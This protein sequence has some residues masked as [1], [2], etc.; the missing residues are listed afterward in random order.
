MYEILRLIQIQK[1]VLNCN[2]LS[3]SSLQIH[4]K[5]VF[6]ENM[7]GSQTFLNVLST[8]LFDTF[9]HESYTGNSF[10]M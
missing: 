8:S 2:L 10:I 6:H 3:Y 9:Y 1:Y 5:D 7:S 4:R